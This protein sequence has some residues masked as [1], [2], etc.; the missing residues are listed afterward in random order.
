MNRPIIP[1]LIAA[2]LGA[3]AA[4]VA[5]VALAGGSSSTPTTTTSAGSRTTP[6]TSGTRREAASTA[7]SATQLYKQSEA[8][9]VAI[10][11]I[12]SEGEDEGTGI[13]LNDKGLILTNAHVVAGAR[14]LTVDT[15]G[16]TSTT[17]SATLVGEEAN[18]DLALIKVDPSGLGLKP[19][20]LASTKNVQVGDAVYAIGNPY[21]LEQTL[22]RGIVSALGRTISAP[23]GAKITGAIQTDAA[24][25]P[26]NSGGPLLNE[27][28][29]VI[30]VNSQIASDAASVAG[31]QP[32]STGV[33]FAISTD[34]VAQAV[35]TIE[36]GNG[37]SST[38]TTRRSVEGEGGQLERGGLEGGRV[39]RG[40]ESGEGEASGSPYGRRYYEAERGA[41][42]ESRSQGE[43]SSATEGAGTEGRVERSGEGEEGS[44]GGREVLIV[45]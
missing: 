17:R 37:V 13:V 31:S 43:G 24:L 44:R 14:S 7:L 25:N 45:P 30:G 41:G 18:D 33:G 9:V 11:A 15:H 21:G 36:A 16:T 22:T 39:E 10:K 27:E 4:A 5:A 34:T 3:A 6:S 40:G 29:E 12:T 28:G 35:K 2:L 42:E 1:M 38:S 32:G 19:L 26:G 23:D 20:Q 8:G